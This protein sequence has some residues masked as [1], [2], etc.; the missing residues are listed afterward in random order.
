MAYRER[1]QSPLTPPRYSV[2]EPGKGRPLLP[3][4]NIRGVQVARLGSTAIQVHPLVLAGIP[5]AA[6]LFFLLPHGD[7]AARLASA[8]LPLVYVLSL[9]LHEAAHALVARRCGIPVHSITL[10]PMGGVTVFERGMKP[11]AEELAV[12]G[13]GPLASLAL[14]SMAA[15]GGAVLDGPLQYLAGSVMLLNAPLFILNALPVLPTDGGRVTRACLWL[16]NRDQ[17]RATVLT[18]RLGVTSGY[19]LG[20]MAGVAFALCLTGLPAMFIVGAT[21]FWYSRT[22]L[23]SSARYLRAASVSGH[24]A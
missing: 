7:P 15:I 14:A 3:P 4:P 12:F 16:V 18:G 5:L 1:R 13:A 21:V 9:L 24:P 17:S 23:R 8:L 2:P 22:V 19:A 10:L 11:G 6:C 20:A